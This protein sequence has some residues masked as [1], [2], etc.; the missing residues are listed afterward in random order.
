MRTRLVRYTWLSL[1][2]GKGMDQDYTAHTHNASGQAEPGDEELVARSQ[3]GDRAAFNTL[4]RRYQGVAYALA[5]RMV[6][7]REV[8]ADVT[9][10]AL[11]AAFRAI[12]SFSGGAFRPWLLRIV[13]NRCMDVFRRRARQPSVSLDALIDGEDGQGTGA[14]PSILSTSDDT[15]SP[16]DAALRTEAISAIEAALLRLP[17]DQRL[18]VILCDVQGL[19]YE[20]IARVMGCPLGTVKSRVARGRA[21]LRTFLRSAELF[22]PAQRPSTGESGRSPGNT[23]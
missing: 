15:W 3:A 12:G 14:S 6:G 8:A 11:I 2:G 19:P 10:E 9:Q 21:T 13:T 20:E 23:S 22:T 17:E 7:D 5:L 1:S 18:A 4:V 16:E